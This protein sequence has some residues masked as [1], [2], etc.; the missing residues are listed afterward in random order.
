[1]IEDATNELLF[2]KFFPKVTT[3]NNMKV[4]R[5]IVENKGLCMSLSV[6]KASHFKTTGYG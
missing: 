6:D 1:M 5:K 2:A 3:F 4:I